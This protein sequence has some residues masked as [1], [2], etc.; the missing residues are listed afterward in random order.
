MLGLFYLIFSI[1]ALRVACWYSG[2]SSSL[3][4]SLAS[5]WWARCFREKLHRRISNYFIE[6]LSILSYINLYRTKF[7][8][9]FLI[10]YK[11]KPLIKFITF[12][13]FSSVKLAS[14]NCSNSSWNSLLPMLAKKRFSTILVSSR[15]SILPWW[16]SILMC[17]SIAA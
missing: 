9:S 2:S 17:F 5:G 8:Y 15:N 1:R 10:L 7:N 13:P 3:E 16:H 12:Y 14:K 6:N 11:L 4:L